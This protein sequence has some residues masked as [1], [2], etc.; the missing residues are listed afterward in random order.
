MTSVIVD[1]ETLNSL[2]MCTETSSQMVTQ[3]A[4]LVTKWWTLFHPLYMIVTRPF[5]CVIIISVGGHEL[6]K[7]YVTAKRYF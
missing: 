7:Q 5:T 2:Q 6:Q 4:I 1:S 3:F